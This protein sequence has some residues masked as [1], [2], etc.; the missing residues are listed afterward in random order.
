MKEFLPIVTIPTYLVLG[1]SDDG[2]SHQVD[3]DGNVNT[4]DLRVAIELSGGHKLLVDLGCRL[5]V[6]NQGITIECLS[7]DIS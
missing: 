2:I 4:D 7:E 6:H 1:M 5:I 3:D